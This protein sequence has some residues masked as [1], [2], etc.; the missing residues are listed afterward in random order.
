MIVSYGDMELHFERTRAVL[1]KKRQSVYFGRHP[2]TKQPRYSKIY[3]DPDVCIREA[4]AFKDLWAS[5]VVPRALECTLD[6]S[7]SALILENCGPDIKSLSK[8]PWSRFAIWTFVERFVSALSAIHELGWVHGDLHPSNICVYAKRVKLIDLGQADRV[9]RVRPGARVAFA[10]FRAPELKGAKGTA[11]VTS[12]DVYSAGKV[13]SWLMD[14]NSCCRDLPEE[15]KAWIQAQLIRPMTHAD[16]AFRPSLKSLNSLIIPKA[17]YIRSLRYTLSHR[18]LSAVID[19]VNLDPATNAWKLNGMDNARSELVLEMNLHYLVAMYVV[20]NGGSFGEIRTERD[21]DEYYTTREAKL[22]KR[23]TSESNHDELDD[24]CVNLHS[25]FGTSLPYRRYRRSPLTQ[26]DGSEYCLMAPP[27]VP[28]AKDIG[29]IVSN[30]DEFKHNWDAM[31]KKMLK[32]VNWENILVA[33][34]SILA[35]LSHGRRRPHSDVD[36]NVFF[37]GLGL[38]KVTAKVIEL[39]DSI[40]RYISESSDIGGDLQIIRDL[41][42]IRFNLPS[43]IPAITLSLRLFR[44]P[45]E[46][47]MFCDVDSSAFGYSGSSVY[48]LPRALRAVTK[49]Y[50][51]VN[52]CRMSH[53]YERRLS[54]YLSRGFAVALSDVCVKQLELCEERDISGSIAQEIPASMERQNF[55]TAFVHSVNDLTP[56]LESVIRIQSGQADFLSSWVDMNA[57]C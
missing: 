11:A 13:L 43:P 53:E 46:V 47:L 27:T 12:T 17:N 52:L 19:S 48:A 37:Y 38:E 21:L 36:I 26:E 41:R 14:Q 20:E 25:V 44:S 35:A 16:P 3:S 49:G 45:A 32:Y 2:L 5:G 55:G 33:G 51:V 7:R 40:R 10:E 56:I 42:S 8:S 1:E 29:I 30:Y 18:A 22:R 23:F 28:Q 39:Y 9:G 57:G 31:T 34:S 4:E 50:N 24:P 54:K 6:D 15:D